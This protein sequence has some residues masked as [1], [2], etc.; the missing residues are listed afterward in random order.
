MTMHYDGFKLGFVRLALQFYALLRLPCEA[1][2][3][4]QYS[5]TTETS[6]RIPVKPHLCSLHLHI[7]I[8]EEIYIPLYSL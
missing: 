2:Y 5:H 6:L 1:V 3:C 7:M 4:M 8:A